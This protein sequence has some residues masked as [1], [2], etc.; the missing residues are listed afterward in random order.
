MFWSHYSNLSH[1]HITSDNDAVKI[2]I[3]L[4]FFLYES[5]PEF[6]YAHLQYHQWKSNSNFTHWKLPLA[7]SRPQFF[8]DHFQMWQR[9]SMFYDLGRFGYGCIVSL[10]IGIM[11]HLMSWLILA[12]LDL[13][14]TR[15][16]FDRR[17]VVVTRVFPS[18][19][20]SV[21]SHHPG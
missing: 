9:Q 15:R 4:G 8:S 2:W 6:I 17:V 16:L 10:K 18:V 21:C 1:I 14:L 20:L 5:N 19:R 13:Y 12:F 7:L 11:G 3:R